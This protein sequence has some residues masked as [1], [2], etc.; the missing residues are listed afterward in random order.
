VKCFDTRKN[1]EGSIK[2]NSNDNCK[3]TG[4]F[5]ASGGCWIGGNMFAPRD[6]APKKR[7]ERKL[8]LLKTYSK[9]FELIDVLERNA[10]YYKKEDPDAIN[11]IVQ[12]KFYSNFSQPYSGGFEREI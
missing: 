5:T 6:D 1:T 2:M 10:E 9:Y 4:S 12:D 11:E 3:K 8:N 7:T